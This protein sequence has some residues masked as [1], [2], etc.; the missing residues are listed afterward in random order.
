MVKAR[1]EVKGFVKRRVG[2]RTAEETKPTE[3][4]EAAR[5]VLRQLLIIYG[6]W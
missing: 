4:Q 1:A 5:V 2:L 3:S 6:Q